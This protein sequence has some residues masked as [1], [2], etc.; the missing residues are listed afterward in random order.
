M[1]NSHTGNMLLQA[2]RSLVIAILKVLALIF[3]WCCKI[4]GNIL[5]K[6]SE[7]TFKLIGK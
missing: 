7:L 4:I 5:I 3:A 6:I 1:N 2:L